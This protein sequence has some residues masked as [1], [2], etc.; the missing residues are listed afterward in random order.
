MK[1]GES[2]PPGEHSDSPRLRVRASVGGVRGTPQV[3]GCIM[4]ASVQLSEQ[5]LYT[6]CSIQRALA[7]LIQELHQIILTL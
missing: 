7:L 1:G 4:P 2:E 5:T 6:A 3:I